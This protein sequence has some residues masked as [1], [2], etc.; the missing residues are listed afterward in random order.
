MLAISFCSVSYGSI[1]VSVCNT[2]AYDI[3]DE[4]SVSG[5]S[6]LASP[7]SLVSSV[8]GS[9]SSTSSS[10]PTLGSVTTGTSSRICMED[11]KLAR[12]DPGSLLASLLLYLLSGIQLADSDPTE[13]PVSTLIEQ[14]VML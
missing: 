10:I 7:S 6:C 9:S 13:S 3:D 1:V 4:A 12:V 8:C 2:G 11:P 5:A 14:G